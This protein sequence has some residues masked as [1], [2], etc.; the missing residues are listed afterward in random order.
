[1]R[2]GVVGGVGGR[3]VR[4]GRGWGGSRGRSFFEAKGNRG[5]LA[6]LKEWQGPCLRGPN[7]IL[8]H[9]HGSWWQFHQLPVAVPTCKSQGSNVWL[10]SER[11]PLETA[12]SLE[13]VNHPQTPNTL[14]LNVCFAC[15]IP[16]VFVKG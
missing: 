12:R 14:F 13:T 8:R 16:P 4:S 2:G 5:F 1:M 7:R 10:T 15:Q 6:P 9:P 11:N 3:R